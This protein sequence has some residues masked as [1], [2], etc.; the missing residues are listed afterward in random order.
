MYS[1]ISNSSKEMSAFSDFPPEQWMPNYLHHKTMVNYIENYAK[2]F[3][4]LKHIKYR[5]EVKRIQKI[6]GNKWKVIV[7]NHNNNQIKEELFDVVMVCSGH[8]SHPNKPY[9]IGQENFKGQIIHSQD[10]KKCSDDYYGKKVLVVGV[11]NSGIDI[12]VE[13][14]NVCDKVNSICIY[15]SHLDLITKVTFI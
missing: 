10:Y 5:H 3:N 8:H 13:L 11:G 7:I 15:T 12:A 1:T 14:S 6:N 9:F 2:Q 4:C